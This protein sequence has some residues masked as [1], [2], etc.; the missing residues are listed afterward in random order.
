MTDEEILQL[1]EDLSRM[2]DEWEEAA[3][4][5]RET[6]VKIII[7]LL[8]LEGDP[9]SPFI[10]RDWAGLFGDAYR[11][12]GVPDIDLQRRVDRIRETYPDANLP[13]Q[14]AELIRE[15]TRSALDRI[16][17]GVEQRL[18]QAR[19]SDASTEAVQDALEKQL[20]RDVDKVTTEMTEAQTVTDRATL[21]S[22]GS[23]FYTYVGPLDEKNRPFCA[24]VASRTQVFT[25]KGIQA[26]NDHPLLN[27]EVPPSVATLCGGYNC[28]HVWA[29][30]DGPPEGWDV[31]DG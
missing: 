10:R 12:A 25:P 15:R 24:D 19:I 22:M 16:G 3:E 6:I 18:R 26:L 14:K 8:A 23:E 21:E 7:A 27:A 29:P 11:R 20:E 2:S 30:V 9:F 31:N 28:R 1:A 4:E 13:A 17:E 5:R